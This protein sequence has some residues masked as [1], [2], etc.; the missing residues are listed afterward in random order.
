[1][2]HPSSS[3]SNNNNNKK[4]KNKN[5]NKK[6]PSSG[7]GK[8]PLLFQ[9]AAANLYIFEACWLCSHIKPPRAERW[10]APTGTAALKSLEV[11]LSKPVQA[12]KK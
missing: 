9:P 4:N 2:H 5:K 8:L 11:D 7:S 10:H 3:S 6:P 12:W 1:M